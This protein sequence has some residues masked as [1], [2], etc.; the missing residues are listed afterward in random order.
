MRVRL[1][2]LRFGTPQDPGFV[3]TATIDAQGRAGESSFTFGEPK[4][5]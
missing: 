5:R 3:A 2:D 1:Y 4:S